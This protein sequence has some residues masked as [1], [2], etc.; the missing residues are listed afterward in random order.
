M[1]K[2][3]FDTFG[4][5]LDMS[6]NSAMKLSTLKEYMLYMKKMGYNALFLYV[7][8]TYEVDGEPFFGYMRGKYTKEEMKALDQYGASIGIEVI[9]CIQTWRTSRNFC[10]GAKR[11][12][13]RMTFCLWAKSVPTS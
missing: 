13:T 10:V 11:L 9:P 4:V 12:S 3:R 8:D 7:E 6:R 2:N 1:A 5:M